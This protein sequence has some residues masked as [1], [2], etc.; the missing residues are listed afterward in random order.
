MK[1]TSEIVLGVIGV[2]LSGLMTLL[3]LFALSLQ[4]NENFKEGIQEAA[5][6]NSTVS[7]ADMNAM[8]EAVGNLGMAMVIASVIGI[9]LG[10]IAVFSLKGNKKPK[11]AGTLLIVGAA[12]VTLI[13]YG[14]G[15]LAGL[16]FLIAGI[17]S[18]VRKPKAQVTV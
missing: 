18:L 17:M 16:M 7:S 8:I 9:I 15:F 11:L 3:G 4:A 5:P 10:L 2:V 6:Q 14:A 12:A 1:R 13:S